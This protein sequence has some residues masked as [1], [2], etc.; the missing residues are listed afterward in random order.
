MNSN[1]SPGRILILSV[2]TGET[3]KKKTSRVNKIPDF[4]PEGEF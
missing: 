4:K 1:D 2:Q 3:G